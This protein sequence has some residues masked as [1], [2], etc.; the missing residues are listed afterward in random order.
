M[1]IVS[2]PMINVTVDVRAQNKVKSVN[3]LWDGTLIATKTSSPWIFTIPLHDAQIGSL[4]LLEAKVTDS[5]N[6]TDITS[7]N[8][9][10]GEDRLPPE[11]TILYPHEG[12]KIEKNSLVQIS[13]D[14]MD[15]NSSI[16]KVQFF[17]DGTL[18]ETKV[19]RPY[20]FSWNANITEGTHTLKAIAFDSAGNTEA[21]S[22]QFSVVTSEVEVVKRETFVGENN[23][24]NSAVERVLAITSP[25]AGN[26]F[27]S[28]IPI[29]F[30]IPTRMRN[31]E[32]T[33][34]VMARKKSGKKQQIFSISGDKIPNNGLASFSW[35]PSQKGEYAI[36]L[37]TKGSST[38]FS[39]KVNIVAK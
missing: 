11:I 23:T 36:Y 12:A 35:T 21:Q 33:I 4:H 27:S 26:E 28:A 30:S 15:K 25:Q 3:L 8:V 5:L 20:Q 29:T 37:Q 18:T 2:P 10:V 39:S 38:D 22:L 14:A 16:K 31:S 13:A 17:I 34:S 32:F 1:G 6:Y 19:I 24:N 7:V 9:K